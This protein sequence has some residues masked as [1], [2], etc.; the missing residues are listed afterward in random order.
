MLA[1]VDVPVLL[2][3]GPTPACG[4]GVT[5]YGMLEMVARS[6]DATL[7]LAAIVLSGRL[8]QYPNLRFISSGSG[9]ATSA[10]AD[11]IDFA[12]KPAHWDDWIGAQR[13]SKKTSDLPSGPPAR[14]GVGGRTNTAPSEMVRK[15]FVDTTADGPELHL[16]NLRV[17]GPEHILSAPT[18][19]RCPPCSGTRWLPSGRFPSRSPSR[20]GFSAATRWKCSTSRTSRRPS[21]SPLRAGNGNPLCQRAHRRQRLPPAARP[22]RPDRADRSCRTRDL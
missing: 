20:S 17:F 10:L 22:G 8:E 19:R 4:N 12:W 18:R 5:D 1:E 3:A 9:G 14:L 2:H 6:C 7:G 21:R 15:L 16:A 13:R 11:R